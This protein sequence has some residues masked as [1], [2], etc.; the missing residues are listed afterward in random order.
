VV[1]VQLPRGRV[2][3]LEIAEAFWSRLACQSLLALNAALTLQTD[4]N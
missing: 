3:L 2:T 4:K 1:L